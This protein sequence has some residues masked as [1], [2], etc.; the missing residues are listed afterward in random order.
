MLKAGINY[1]FFFALLNY[2]CFPRV[3]MNSGSTLLWSIIGISL[4]FVVV[5][6]L[7]EILEKDVEPRITIKEYLSKIE[8]FSTT[9][10]FIGV[11]NRFGFAVDEERKKIC[12]IDGMCKDIEPK[13]I[14][15]HDL[16]SVELLEDSE[17]ITKTERSSQIGGALIGGLALGGIGAVI[18]GLSGRTETTGKV[19]K[20]ILRLIVNDMAKPIHEVYFLNLENGIGKK[21]SRY[22]DA[23]QKAR[24]WHSLMEIV[25]KRADMEDKENAVNNIVKT[26][27]NSVADEIKKLAELRDTGI[28]SDTEFQQQK[29]KLLT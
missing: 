2:L 29:E 12:L 18:G 1:L 7:N 28:L 10:K 6:I 13:I 16:L 11:K 15:Y 3:E 21:S 22:Q 17:T 23:I 19:G 25:I 14:S 5:I 26:S 20:I 9:Q 4:F 24:H 8:N 27:Q